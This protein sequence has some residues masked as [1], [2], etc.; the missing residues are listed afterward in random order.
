L[1]PLSALA[2]STNELVN[3]MVLAEAGRIAPETEKV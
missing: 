3:V 2:G 1:I